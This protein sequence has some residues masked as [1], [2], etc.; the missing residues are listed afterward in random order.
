[1]IQILVDGE[2]ISNLC[3]CHTHR[4]LSI[5]T[6]IGIL[7]MHIAKRDNIKIGNFNVGTTEFSLMG[8][9]AMIEKPKEFHFI[10]EQP[11]I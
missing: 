7:M 2:D 5:F 11:K 1:M 4:D 6:R 3:K 9:E 8:L 10:V